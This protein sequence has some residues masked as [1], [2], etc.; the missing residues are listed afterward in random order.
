MQPGP[1]RPKPPKTSQ[2]PSPRPPA[3]LTGPVRATVRNTRP[4]GG[5]AVVAVLGSVAA[6]GGA[7]GVAAAATPPAGLG[8]HRTA[9]AARSA[10]PT[11]AG[12]LALLGLVFAG[13]SACAPAL[14]RPLLSRGVDDQVI[15]E[16]EA[17]AFIA[18]LADVDATDAATAADGVS[19][20]T[21]TPAAIALFQS[22]FTA[23]RRHLPVLA[24]P[25]VDDALA[26][27]TITQAQANRIE[28]RMKVRA[29]LRLAGFPSGHTEPLFTGRLP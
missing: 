26:A 25:L 28:Q 7:G 15:T 6:L 16:A 17:D 9:R 5:R 2:K 27:G 23:I 4:P 12:E 19:P 11:P 14:A 21:P 24:K 3:A 1:R 13:L 29:Q 10:D 20:G 22:V 18:R 8:A